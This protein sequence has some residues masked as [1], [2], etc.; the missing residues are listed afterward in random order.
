MLSDAPDDIFFSI[1]E[2]CGA[3]DHAR[4]MACNRTMLSITTNCAYRQFIDLLAPPKDSP[5]IP[6]T[7]GDLLTMVD[8][9]RR[10]SDSVKAARE[11]CNL[12]ASYGLTKFIGRVIGNPKLTMKILSGGALSLAARGGHLDTVEFIL[13]A[14]KPVEA[15]ALAN[16]AIHP[17]KAP[18]L[19][20]LAE[21]SIRA[22]AIPGDA[23]VAYIAKLL[24]EARA[25]VMGLQAGEDGC[26]LRLLVR[27]CKEANKGGSS[28]GYIGTAGEII[29]FLANK[30]AIDYRLP[31]IPADGPSMEHFRLV[32]V[33]TKA[34]SSACYWEDDVLVKC[35]T[36]GF[37]V[38]K[39]AK[40]WLRAAISE[41]HSQTTSETFNASS[42]FRNGTQSRRSLLL[43][44]SPSPLFLAVTASRSD[45]AEMMLRYM[46]KVCDPNVVLPSGKSP[47][48][49]ACEIGASNGVIRALL[50]GG[51]KVDT[52]TCTG[53][54]ALF[55]AVEKGHIAAVETLCS[56][57]WC[58]NLTHITQRTHGGVSPFMLAENK[59]RLQM[60][61][62]MLEAYSREARRALDLLGDGCGVS[63]GKLAFSV[64]HPYLNKMCDKYRAKLEA[65]AEARL[66]RG[67]REVPRLKPRPQ[68]AAPCTREKSLTPRRTLQRPLLTPRAA[69]EPAKVSVAAS[70]Y[71]EVHQKAPEENR[72]SVRMLE[73]R[74][75][76]RIPDELRTSGIRLESRYLHSLLVRSRANSLARK[77]RVKRV[78]EASYGGAVHCN[79]LRRGAGAGKTPKLRS[80][81]VTRREEGV[82]QV[83]GR[84]PDYEEVDRIAEFLDGYFGLR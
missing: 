70:R 3:S 1:L 59:G 12:A 15:Y 17:S 36:E 27:K 73:V 47:L 57:A 82:G 23:K 10:S 34:L 40:L 41:V 22:A 54:N 35:I 55:A 14:L 8:L 48:Y 77:R 74:E 25:D 61:L 52:C 69:E 67:C 78:T 62:A 11:A 42:G 50:L 6:R 4:L 2:F 58:V 83:G 44:G 32:E 60:M 75:P 5:I 63:F 51:A 31:V 7:L 29:R 18:I 46:L 9:A 16:P 24:L 26:P 49:L 30:C 71:M 19:P 33:V 76:E 66:I 72:V 84:G 21:C 37:A 79:F 39:A 68:S 81:S 53:R 20:P 80:R 56:T 64:T 13:K 28:D 38:H 65:R 43:E 45:R